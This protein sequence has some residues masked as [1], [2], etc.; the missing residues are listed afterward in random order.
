MTI[1]YG[2]VEVFVFVFFVC[3]GGTNEAAITTN[4]F[5]KSILN[6]FFRKRE[7][8]MMERVSDALS[9]RGKRNKE[10]LCV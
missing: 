2:F 4:S 3:L 1:S 10:K 8:E 7:R 6:R 9:G 5:K